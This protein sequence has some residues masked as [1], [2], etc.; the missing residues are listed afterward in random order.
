MQ[1][2]YSQKRR[3]IELIIIPASS[4]G[5]FLTQLDD[6]CKER[7]TRLITVSHVAHTDGR[8]FPLQRYAK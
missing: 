3:G 2:L 5:R 6:L 4:E 8:V 1:A 7:R